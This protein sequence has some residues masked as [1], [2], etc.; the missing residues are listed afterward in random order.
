MQ[1]AE[2]AINYLHSVRSEMDHLER[3]TYAATPQAIQ[4]ALHTGDSICS[5]SVPAAQG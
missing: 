4:I 3:S 2:R 5:S 1:C